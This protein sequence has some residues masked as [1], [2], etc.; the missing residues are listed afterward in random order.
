MIENKVFAMPSSEQLGS[1]RRKVSRWPHRPAL[2]LLAVSPPDFDPGNWTHLS[3]AECADLILDALPHRNE[4]EVETMRRYAAL[5]K[6]LHALVSAVEVHSDE[7]PVWLPAD[8]LDAVHSAQMRAALHKARAQRVAKVV[9]SLSAGIREDAKGGFT[10]ATPLVEVIEAA[11][12]DSMRVR[13][14]WQLQGDQFRRAVIYLDSRL[15]GR[16]DASRRRREGHSRE[17]PEFFQF[18]SS[19]PQ[20]TNGRKEFNHY[21]PDFVYR[22]VKVPGLTVGELKHVA[23]EIHEELNRLRG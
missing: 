9:G 15:T 17:H 4:Y 22:Y 5:M 3:Y 20:V 18:P 10:N 8:L 11:R 13:L 2:I 7:E 19:L 6:D 16:T 21:S 23:I 1:Y 12:T 14:G